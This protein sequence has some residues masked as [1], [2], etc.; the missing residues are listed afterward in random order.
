MANKRSHGHGRAG[1][2]PN[3][4]TED[5]FQVLPDRLPWKPERR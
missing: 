3:D 5:D 2:S 1:Q 4:S